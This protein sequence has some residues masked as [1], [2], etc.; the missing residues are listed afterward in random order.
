MSN[1]INF[2]LPEGMRSK[3]NDLLERA[4]LLGYE[5]VHWINIINELN[6]WFDAS[7]KPSRFYS[8][9]FKNRLNYL[10]RIHRSVERYACNSFI[11]EEELQNVSDE[12]G[13][14]IETLIEIQESAIAEYED[15]VL[16]NSFQLD[17]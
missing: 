13:K 1:H 15:L 17:Q 7:I 9:I 10:K 3:F 8:H 4:S 16:Q 11:N 2:S 6:S 5:T 14:F 12:L